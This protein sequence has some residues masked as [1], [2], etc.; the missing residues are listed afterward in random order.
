MH[1][2]DTFVRVSRQMAQGGGVQPAAVLKCVR[3][4]I[5]IW[6][7]SSEQQD[8]PQHHHMSHARCIQRVHRCGTLCALTTR[9]QD[10]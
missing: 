9:A 5:W 3:S 1:D 10:V 6:K 2:A 7:V 4:L 8:A